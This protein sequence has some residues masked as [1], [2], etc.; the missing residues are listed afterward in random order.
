MTP[1][2]VVQGAS[3]LIL[4]LPHT[5]TFVPDDVRGC[6]N[7]TGCKL[8]DTDWHI[9]QLYQG[10]LPEITTVKANYHRYFVDVNRDPEG[11][12]LYPGQN[13][14]PLVPL[15]DFDD[16]NI[17]DTPPDGAEV[18]RRLAISHAP[19]HAAMQA[20]IDRVHALHGF[21]IHYDCHSIRSDIPFLFE[22]QLPVLNIGTNDGSTCAPAIS[23]IVE[24]I[25]RSSGFSMVVNGRFKGGWTTRHYAR[26]NQGVHTIQLEIAQRAYLTNEAAPWVYDINKADV[27][28]QTL[29]SILT[30]L[31]SWRPAQ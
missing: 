16:Q 6:L 10:L 3:P 20:E 21:V 25:A 4:G 19:Y 22:G 24:D 13:T 14:T 29:Q 28:R 26:P 15:T 7:E 2:S 9:D 12:S 30:S 11:H 8:A 23:K 18:Q 5:G 17:W 27:L 31:N 1:V